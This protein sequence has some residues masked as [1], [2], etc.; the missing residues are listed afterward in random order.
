MIDQYLSKNLKVDEEVVRIVRRYPLPLGLKI[1]LA[2]ALMLVDFFFL[3][4]LFRQGGWGIGVFFIILAGL[5]LS[6]YRQWFLWSMNVIIITNQR[7]IDLDQQGFFNRT[8][9][10]TTFAKIQDVS[11]TIR[12]LLP[13]VFH[14]G[15][16][17]VQTAGGQ[18][19]LELKGVHKPESVQDVITE[20]QRQSQPQGSGPVAGRDLV[21]PNPNLKPDEQPD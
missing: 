10:E 7:L 11:Y 18:T 13:T 1:S 6:A 14:Y 15:T 2:A 5:A 4:W 20:L 17:V 12:G 8:V 21:E 3:T 19:N 16:V 9:S